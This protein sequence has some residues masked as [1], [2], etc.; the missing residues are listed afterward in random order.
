MAHTTVRTPS[1]R[2]PAREPFGGRSVPDFAPIQKLPLSGRTLPGLPSPGRQSF[3]AGQAKDRVEI[4]IGTPG[5]LTR[6]GLS[7]K[8]SGVTKRASRAKTSAANRSDPF[9][10]ANERRLSN[11]AP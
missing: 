8:L 5:G 2:P 4:G 3:K 9:Q 1:R 6:Q 10:A 11:R 7:A